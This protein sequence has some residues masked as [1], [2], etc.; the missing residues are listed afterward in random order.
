MLQLSRQHMLAIGRENFRQGSVRTQ[1]SHKDLLCTCSGEWAL[2]LQQV[3]PTS[4]PGAVRQG[5]VTQ[6]TPSA[7]CHNMSTIHNAISPAITC[8]GVRDLL[9]QM[10]LQEH[11]RGPQLQQGS[12]AWV[13]QFDQAHS[14][15]PGAQRLP[16]ATGQP[17]SWAEE[18]AQS[19]SLQPPLQGP[20][21]A[22]GAAWAEQYTASSAP[23]AAWAQEFTEAKV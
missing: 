3:Q 7:D 15:H 13:K 21:P 20:L 2:M 11:N 16:M 1:C 12:S 18:Y 22:T 6:E 17:G 4:G 14:S 10:L 5:P 23:G 19:S 8:L 9:K